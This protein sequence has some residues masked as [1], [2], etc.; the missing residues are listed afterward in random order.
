MPNFLSKD[1]EPIWEKAKAQA[2]KQG[3]GDNYGY[4]TH[5]F[6][7]MGG[8]VGANEPAQGDVVRAGM[9]I[10]DTIRCRASFAPDVESIKDKPWKQGEPVKFVY[11]PE[12]V[13]SINAGFRRG[14][15]KLCVA[16]DKSTAAAVQSSLDQLHSDRP[17]QRP[18]GCVE[19][20]EQEASIIASSFDYEDGRGVVIT[21]EPTALGAANVNGKIHWSWSPS[22]TTDAN[23]AECKC[24]CG[25]DKCDCAAPV[26]EFPAGVRGSAENPA[27]VTGIDFVLGTLTNRPAFREMPPVKAEDATVQA[28]GTSDGAKKGWENRGAGAWEELS[29]HEIASTNERL[30]RAITAH[31]IQSSLTDGDTVASKTELWDALLERATKRHSG[32]TPEEQHEHN[33]NYLRE[34]APDLLKHYGRTARASDSTPATAIKAVEAVAEPIFD[35]SGLLGLLASIRLAHWNANTATNEHKTLGEL[36]EVIDG[37]VDSFVEVKLGKTGVKVS[38][39]VDGD[40]VVTNGCALVEQL[41]AGLVAGEDD[42]LLNL[43]AD[44][45]GE[46]NKVKYLLKVTPEVEPEKVIQT[47]DSATVD[48]IYARHAAAKARVEAIVERVKGKAMTADDIYNRIYSLCGS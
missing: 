32:L 1:D 36:Y 3:K 17:K 25:K 13:H 29:P 15:I 30:H 18:Y 14:S 44:M 39:S 45:E 2:R 9:D 8:K 42:D 19:H 33:L 4:I 7:S 10:T 31:R 12:G 48:S 26:L 24:S 16:V 6:K 47:A 20:R 28:A 41:R 11:M 23:Y 46:F 22:F 35:A 43:L 37:L 40:E 27:Q 21:A 38:D 5:I 34:N